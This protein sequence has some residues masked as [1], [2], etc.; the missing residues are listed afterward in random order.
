MTARNSTARA[1]I[2]G[3]VRSALAGTSRVPRDS[4]PHDY[5]DRRESSDLVE[6]FRARTEEYRAAV[7]VTDSTNVADTVLVALHAA[8]AD[9]T[10]VPT[11]IPSHWVQP[12]HGTHRTI[13]D[14]TALDTA[15]LDAC[16]AVV[17]T[18]FGGIATTGTVVL[19]HGPGQG[20]RALTLIPDTHVCLVQAS[21]IVDDVPAVLARL[22]PNHPLTFISGP[23]ATSDI[24]LD[25]VEGVHGPRSLHVIVIRDE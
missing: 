24:E 25:R 3:S 14:D 17:T 1:T 15:T 21:R 11:G 16:D 13:S 19:D 10:I 2:L 8:R 4:V 7:H 6:L 18:S 9:H 12:V 23:S 5:R 22:D 20:R